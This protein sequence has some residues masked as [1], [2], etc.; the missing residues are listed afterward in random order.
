M[1]EV[2]L[3]K[4]GLH[5]LLGIPASWSFLEHEFPHLSL[6]KTE[7]QL[8]CN[9]V[10]VSSVQQ[11]DSVIQ[12]FSDSFPLW[13]ITHGILAIKK[14]ETMPFAATWMDLEMIILSEVSQSETN[15]IQYH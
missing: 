3:P 13:V 5:S 12:S 14:N 1:Q 11:S 6:F 9:V 4:F 15:I 10:L 8:I 7:G 2:T